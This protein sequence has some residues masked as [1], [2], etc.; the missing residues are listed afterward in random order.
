MAVGGNEEVLKLQGEKTETI[1]LGGKMVLPGLIDSHVHPPAR[2]CTSSI[3]RFPRWNRSTTCWPTSSRAERV[4]PEGSGS[5]SARSSSPGSRSSAIPRGPSWTPW[6][7]SI[8]SC[9]ATGPDA[10]AQLAGAQGSGI[11]KDFKVTEATRLRSKR[12][13]PPASRPASSAAARRY[14]KSKSIAAS[15]RPQA[16]TT[17]PAGTSCS[18]TTTPSA[19]PPSPTAT[20]RS[21]AIARYQQLR[22]PGE[23]TVRVASRTASTTSGRIE[24]PSKK[25]HPRGRRPPAPQ[26]ER[27]LRIVGI[28][29]YLDGGMLT[30]SAYMREPWGVSKIYSITDPQYRGVLFIQPRTA[31]ADRADDGRARP[32]VHGPQRRRRRGARICST[33]TRRSNK[34]IARRARTR[35]CITHCNF[36]SREAVEQMRGWASS[37]TS[38]RP[39]STSMRRRS[40]PSSAT[41][42]C[43]TSSRSR[44]VF[45]RR[46]SSA[47]GATTCRRS[48][49]CGAINPYNPFLGMWV[50]LTRRARWLEGQLHP[51]E[52][53]TREQ[54]IRFYTIEQR[55]HHV[56]RR[57]QAVARTGKLADLIVVDRDL[58]TARW[59]T[60]GRRRCCGRTWEESWCIRDRWACPA[61]ALTDELQRVAASRDRSR[62]RRERPL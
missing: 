62:A 26:G 13:R 32:A 54:A 4:V 53:L 60:C 16:D 34:D 56:P 29:I 23:L 24:K 40:P 28:K 43:A 50:T 21:E 44:A 42:G 46:R 14:V 45:E 59:T 57:R 17:R 49:R 1:D 51:E 18:P 61:E 2:R 52:A 35:P 55:V 11:D 38:S 37:P 19:S 12:I 47:A 6:R 25:R 58:L 3:T 9:F 27:W 8:P 7:R 15:R 22:E 5:T 31:A 30:G 10:I 39:G 41:S 33:P 36:M 20:R 48:A